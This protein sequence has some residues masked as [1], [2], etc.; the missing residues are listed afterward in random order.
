[1]RHQASVEKAHWRRERRDYYAIP[2]PDEPIVSDWK[3]IKSISMVYRHREGGVNEHD[4]NTFF[5]SSLPA[6]VKSVS[7]HLRDR[8]TIEHGG[9]Y[10]RD[11]TVAE[12]AR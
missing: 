10:V 6:K 11:V 9:H 2:F 12:D 4:Q 7:R 1:M 5:I 3:G 8:W